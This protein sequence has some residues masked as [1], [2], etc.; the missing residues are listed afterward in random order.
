MFMNPNMMNPNMMNPNMMNPNMMNPNMMNPN[1]MNPNMMNPNMMNPNMMNP[2]MMNPGFN[3]GMGGFGMNPNQMNMNMFNNIN[4]M[5][6][7]TNNFNNMN[8]NNNFNNM[9]N[10]NN[11]FNNTNN[12]KVFNDKI[13]NDKIYNNDNNEKIQ[14]S[15]M[16]PI[17][18]KEINNKKYV[19]VKDINKIKNNIP[20]LNII[21]QASTG[22]KV[23]IVSELDCT[24]KD[25]FRK[26]I[27]IL[28]LP[29][30][31]L[32]KEIIFLY[33][34]KKMDIDSQDLVSSQFPRD[35]ITV[36]VVDYN[37]VI[38]A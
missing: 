37:N 15:K 19:E 24:I 1:M 16:K 22:L 21:F 2:N 26:Y 6:N 34:A 10:G 32:G 35:F 25:L 5:N 4:N 3:V 38:G 11:N 20:I 17:L 36:T 9:N 30:R 12:E 27:N 8:N 29:E 31:Y 33:N 28:G 13:C 23:N 14:N 7:G 18:P